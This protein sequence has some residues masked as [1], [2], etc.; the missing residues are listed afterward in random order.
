MTMKNSHCALAAL[1]MLSGVLLAIGCGRSPIP[2]A[3]SDSYSLSRIGGTSVLAASPGSLDLTFAVPEEVQ[4]TLKRKCHICHGGTDTKGGFDF[5]QMIYQKEPDA[6]WQPMDLAGAT[7][8]KLAILP[9]NGKPAQMPKKAGSI[10]NPLTVEEAN[11]VAKWTDY[12]FE[13]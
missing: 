3:D 12:P 9:V 13:R 1:A 10:W 11:L 8:I 6:E 7:R 2:N 5:K 4:I